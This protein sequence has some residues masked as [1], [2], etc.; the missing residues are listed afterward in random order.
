MYL[1]Y[2]SIE[3]SDEVSGWRWFMDNVTKNIGNGNKTL[4]WSWIRSLFVWEVS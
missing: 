3:R 1:T 4:F 2:Y